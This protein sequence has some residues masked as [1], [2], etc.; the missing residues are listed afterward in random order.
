MGVKVKVIKRSDD[1]RMTI[2]VA[3]NEFVAEKEALNLSYD[4]VKNYKYSV[5]VLSEV[6]GF[7]EQ[8]L[9]NEIT[10]QHFYDWIK[11]MKEKGSKPA[12]INHYLRDC[13]TFIYWCINK[14][15]ITKPFKISLIKFQEESLKF[16]TDEE[17]DLLLKKPKGDEGF[18][19]WRLWAV[20]NWILATGNRASTVCEIKIGDIDYVSKE[21]TL[22]Q[23]KNKRLQIIPLS[24][25]LETVIKGYCKIWRT[26]SGYDDYLFPAI[27]DEKLSVS[28]LRSS[29][30]RYTKRRGVANHSLHGLRHTFARYWVKNNGN[31]F[32]LQK[33]LGHSTLEMTRKYVKLFADDLKEDYEIYSPLDTIKRNNSKTHVVKRVNNNQ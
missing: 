20:V 9:L 7:T 11:Y 27:N 26:Y 3:L 25:S 2:G 13:R 24:P 1:E 15:Y 4:T 31:M 22:R 18:S 33:I 14:E 19:D 30:V 28:G 29:F 17:V 16:F 6:N 23:T 10:I 21:I 5:R 8:S 12:T 32:V